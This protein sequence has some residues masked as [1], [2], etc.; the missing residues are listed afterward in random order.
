VD[1]YWR[2]FCAYPEDV[3][4]GLVEYDPN[5]HEVQTMLYE[6]QL[7]RLGELADEERMGLH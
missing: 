4:S 7:R 3:R 5:I 1:F 2:L 6:S